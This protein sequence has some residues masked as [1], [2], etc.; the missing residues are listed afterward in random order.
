MTDFLFQQG[1]QKS[2]ALLAE[3]LEIEKLINSKL[4]LQ[5]IELEESLIA[6]DTQK[7]LNWCNQNKTKLQKIKSR[8]E[9]S[10][11]YIFTIIKTHFTKWDL[12][13][14]DFVEL[15]KV[16]K[17]IEAVQYARKYLTPLSPSDEELGQVMALLGN[18]L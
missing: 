13:I 15:I 12:R 8:F 18:N 7:S 6:K 11:I 1:F 14:Q 10:H 4:Y 2:G 17:R 3:N 5:I 16:E 9:V